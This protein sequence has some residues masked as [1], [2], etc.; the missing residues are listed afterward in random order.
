MK[1]K[2]YIVGFLY[3]NVVKRRKKSIYVNKNE[4]IAKNAM[5]TPCKV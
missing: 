4:K 2:I 1:Y 5:K 3:K